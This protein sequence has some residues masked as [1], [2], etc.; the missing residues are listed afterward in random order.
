MLADHE[1]EA[2][3]GIAAELAGTDPVLAR[4]LSRRVH[5]QAW[6][7]RAIGVLAAVTAVLLVATGVYTARVPL[8]FAGVT[9]GTALLGLWLF[10]RRSP[11]EPGSP[12]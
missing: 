1:K 9:G 5:R 10:R 3:D 4:S 11:A 2:L 6:R 7:W 8:V 12:Q